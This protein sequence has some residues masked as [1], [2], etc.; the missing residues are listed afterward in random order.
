LGYGVQAIPED[1]KVILQVVFIGVMMVGILL[2]CVR[3]G[4]EGLG[5]LVVLISGIVFYIYILIDLTLLKQFD[6]GSHI[7]SFVGTLLLFLAGFLFY[8][9]ARRSKAHTA[10]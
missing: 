7:A 8:S 5:G 10:I 3:I 9:C 6:P 1:S 4:R 2:D